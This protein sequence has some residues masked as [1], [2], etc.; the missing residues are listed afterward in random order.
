MLHSWLDRWDESNARRGDASKALADFVLNAERAFPPAPQAS[1]VAAF[2][3]LSERAAG[4]P[5]FFD[6]PPTRPTDGVESEDGWI[7]FSTSL[8]SGVERND[9]VRAK[10]TM[11]RESDHALIVFHHWNARARKPLLARY[12]ARRGLTVAEMALPFHLERSRPGASNA[13]D[14]LSP[15]LGRTL[16]SMRQAVLDGRQLVAILKG[17]GYGT[18]SVLGMSL[19]S[20]VAGL[21]AAHDEAVERA[22]LFL[23]AGSLADMVWTGRATQHIRAS[24]EGRIDPADLRRAWRPLDLGHHANR[25]ARPGLEL[26]IVLAKR[27]TVVQPSLSEE[28]VT[29][30]G[31]AGGRPEVLH[32]NCGHY[33]LSLPPY[34]FRAGRGALG[35]LKGLP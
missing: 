12:F 20:W 5:A 35:L 13:D 34:V 23:T 1:D 4:D 21:V 33:S 29:K 19:G 6:P 26:L 18:I 3:D 8:P 14:M 25:L 16:G 31:A 24:L 27:D 9:T 22:A 28:L 30:L 17:R 32:L 2:N 10:V 15:N 7:T 11:A